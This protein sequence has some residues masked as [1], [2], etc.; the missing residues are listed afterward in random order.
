MNPIAKPTATRIQ[1]VVIE[2]NI[3]NGTALRLKLQSKLLFVNGAK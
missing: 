2:Q 3:V 1:Q